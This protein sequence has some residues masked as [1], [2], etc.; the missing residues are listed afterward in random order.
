V[1]KTARGG[2]L[3]EKKKAQLLREIIEV[4]EGES[5]REATRGYLKNVT[6][7]REKRRA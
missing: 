1:R 7:A 6:R 5:A 3:L 2:N 4:L